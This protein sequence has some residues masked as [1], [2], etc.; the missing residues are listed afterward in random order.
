LMGLRLL[1]DLELSGNPLLDLSEVEALAKRGVQVHYYV[2]FENPFDIVIEEAIR[3]E[4]NDIRGPI[5]QTALESILYIN[6]SGPIHSL[7]GI[8][9][10]LNLT[11]LIVRYTSSDSDLPFNDLTPISQLENL[12]NL[13]IRD[14]PISDIGPLATLLQIDELSLPNNQIADIRPLANLPIL[15]F[16]NL[17]GNQVVDLLPLRELSRLSTINLTNNEVRDLSPLLEMTNLKSVWVR[18]NPLSSE[19]LNDVVPA[20]RDRGIFVV[21]I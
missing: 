12:T 18:G 20:L 16:L 14:T 19:T 6:F 8:E 7:S 2:P 3:K 21:G 13:T 4:L 15:R 17:A 10:L 5:S 1:R 11:T 9:R